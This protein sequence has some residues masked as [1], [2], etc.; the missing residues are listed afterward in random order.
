MLSALQTEILRL[1]GI[2]KKISGWI[3][4]Q[5]KTSNSQR[6]NG[7]IVKFGNTCACT[8]AHVHIHAHTPI[9][10]KNTW[11]NKQCGPCFALVN[12]S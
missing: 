10:N 4:N 3:E 5:R 1:T 9:Q 11:T 8:C 12:Y 2:K 6:E 7:V